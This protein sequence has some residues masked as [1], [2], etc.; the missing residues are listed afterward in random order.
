VFLMS[1]YLAFQANFSFLLPDLS[2]KTAEVTRHKT[3]LR[4]RLRHGLCMAA[5]TTAPDVADAWFCIFVHC[6]SNKLCLLSQTCHLFNA[7]TKHAATE[8]LNPRK[9]YSEALCAYLDDFGGNTCNAR[10]N[11]N[12]SKVTATKLHESSLPY[13]PVLC[14]KIFKH[15]VKKEVQIHGVR[16]LDDFY[17]KGVLDRT[18]NIYSGQPPFRDSTKKLYYYEQSMSKLMDLLM[19]QSILCHCFQMSIDDVTHFAQELQCKVWLNEQKVDGTNVTQVL[20]SMTTWTE[21]RSLMD[22]LE[23]DEFAIAWPFDCETHRVLREMLHTEDFDKINSFMTN[24]LNYIQAPMTSYRD[25]DES[26]RFFAINNLT[27]VCKL[28][29]FQPS[30]QTSNSYVCV[31]DL[32][33]KHVLCSQ[34]CSSLKICYNVKDIVPQRE[35]M[36]AD[37]TALVGQAVDVD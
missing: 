31:M 12:I 15:I 2:F 22:K 33:E 32:T 10:L 20:N 7:I 11:E 17:K 26:K 21:T 24:I 5:A 13:L 16:L 4:G 34:G 19:L 14:V 30:K 27:C 36:L 35:R 23:E 29:M 37:I 25:I 6:S 9:F 1:V 8:K 18:T 28:D 3:R